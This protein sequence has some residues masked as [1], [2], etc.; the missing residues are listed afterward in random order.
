MREVRKEIRD[1]AKEQ[2]EDLKRDLAKIK[3]DL[4]E[5]EKR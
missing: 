2:E 3:E 4:M 1:S 5:R